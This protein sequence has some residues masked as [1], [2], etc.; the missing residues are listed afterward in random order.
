MPSGS[1]KPTSAKIGVC[2]RNELTEGLVA[3]GYVWIQ[4]KEDESNSVGKR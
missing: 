4:D 1:W 3:R 2:T